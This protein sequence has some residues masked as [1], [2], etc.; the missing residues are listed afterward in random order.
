MHVKDK[1]HQIETNFENEEMQLRMR[2]C[3]KA[4]F[5]NINGLGKRIYWDVNRLLNQI[6]NDQ[7]FICVGAISLQNFFAP[8][9][10]FPAR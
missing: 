10:S 4:T 3:I 1:K 9:V 5:I 8:M 2:D 7:K 6:Q